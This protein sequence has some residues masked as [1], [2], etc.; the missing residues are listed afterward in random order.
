MLNFQVSQDGLIEARVDNWLY[1]ISQLEFKFS[2]TGYKDGCFTVGE[3][4]SLLEAIEAA[5]K[6]YIESTHA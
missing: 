4:S 2:V 5:N 1:M 6:H 3:F